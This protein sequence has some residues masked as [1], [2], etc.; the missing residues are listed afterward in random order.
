MSINA[1]FKNHVGFKEGFFGIE[2]HLR[3]RKKTGKND[4]I[5]KMPEYMS[6]LFLNCT[7]T[8]DTQHNC[9][10]ECSNQEG[11]Q[12]GSTFAV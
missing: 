12:G 10:L 1:T 6:S 4:V 2:L 11:A 9:N 5:S 7:G 3:Q 8:G